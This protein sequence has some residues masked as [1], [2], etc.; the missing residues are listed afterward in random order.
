MLAQN[1]ESDTK[2]PSKTSTAEKTEKAEKPTGNAGKSNGK[3]AA[4]ADGP[5]RLRATLELGQSIW[6]DNMRRGLLVSGEL[7]ALVK[8]GVRGLTSNPTIFEKA[9]VS[10]SDYEEA[11]RSLAAA[12]L[13]PTQIY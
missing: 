1:R 5:A 3:A 13:S 12:G 8:A 9:I 4:K 10:S 7:A 11:L 2:M 6:Y